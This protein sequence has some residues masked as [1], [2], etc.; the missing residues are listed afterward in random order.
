MVIFEIMEQEPPNYAAV[1]LI[2]FCTTKKKEE[3]EELMVG[4]NTSLFHNSKTKTCASS[5]PPF[6][7][8]SY[9]K[10]KQ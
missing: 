6:K 7:L 5:F 4:E 1:F 3:I 10:V 8:S 2:V 9:K